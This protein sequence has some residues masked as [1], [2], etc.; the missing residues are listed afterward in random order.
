MNLAGIRERPKAELHIHMEGSVS[1]DTADAIAARKG[2]ETLPK[3]FYDLAGGDEFTRVF[4]RLADLMK[5]EQDFFEIARDFAGRQAADGIVYTETFIQPSF[6]VI[7]GVPAE[8]LFNGVENG[9]KEGEKLHGGRVRVICSVSRVFGPAAAFE[10]LDMIEKHGGNMV[11]GIDLAGLKESPG[12]PALYAPVFER[13]RSMG[14]RTVAHSGEFS[15]PD[16]LRSTLDLIK[17]ERIGHGVAAGWDKE[18]AARLADSGVPLEVCPTSNIALTA[19]PSLKEHPVRALYEM[20]VPIVINTDDPALFRTTLSEELDLLH[21]GMGFSD[22][23]I[24]ELMDNAFKYSFAEHPQSG[25][26]DSIPKGS[27]V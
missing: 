14:L 27:L 9:L 20:G 12:D 19:V 21:T 22:S 5:E 6:H 25:M 26:R 8:V 23:E 10:T 24:L 18:L 2:L 1:L 17:P 16:V 4:M 13:A 3:S 7:R 15:S 11:I